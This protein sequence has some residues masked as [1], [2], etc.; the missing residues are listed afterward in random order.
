[1]DVGQNIFSKVTVKN[2][3][4]RVYARLI[5]DRAV[6]TYQIGNIIYRGRAYDRQG[7]TLVFDT[8]D[9]LEI[10][11]PADATVSFSIG[12]EMFFIKT[13]VIPKKNHAVFDIGTDL[14]KLQRRD[15]FRLI[16][17]KGYRARFELR[18][19]DLDQQVANFPVVDLSGGGLSFEM[20]YATDS[21]RVGSQV[22]GFLKIGDLFT[23]PVVG[24]VRHVRPFG[25]MGSGLF[26]CGIQFE[27]LVSTD[28]EEI[29]QMVMKIHRESFSKFKTA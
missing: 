9:P 14:Y 2:D 1:M 6:F 26:R 5:E 17:P 18:S 10:Q 21:M 29:I 28:R 23:K 19:I 24:L 8:L 13:R 27:G 25:S 3:R 11:Q 4:E 16:I 20:L 12:P 7:R 22:A 15:N